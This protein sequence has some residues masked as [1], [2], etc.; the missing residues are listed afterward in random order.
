MAVLRRCGGSTDEKAY[1]DHKT[2][3]QNNVIKLVVKLSSTE[4]TTEGL[5]IV[6]SGKLCKIFFSPSNLLFAYLL[7]IASLIPREERCIKFFNLYS[8][9]NLDNKDG[10]SVW[11]ARLLKLSDVPML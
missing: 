6:E 1:N 11:K 3:V 10:K 9:A 7:S 5:R 2:H 8:F 4:Y